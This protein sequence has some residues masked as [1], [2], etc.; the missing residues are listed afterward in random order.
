MRFGNQ[1]D[2][3]KPYRLIFSRPGIFNKCTKANMVSHLF[4]T[5]MKLKGA[6][7]VSTFTFFN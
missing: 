6:K 4:Q 2:L 1:G 7:F 3:C 5:E